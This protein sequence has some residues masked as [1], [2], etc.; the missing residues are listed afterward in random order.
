M[1]LIHSWT[2]DDYYKQQEREQEI[3]DAKATYTAKQVQEHLKQAEERAKRDSAA[4]RGQEEM[5]CG[6]MFDVLLFFS[7]LSGPRHSLEPNSPRSQPSPED[8][9]RGKVERWLQSD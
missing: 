2:K 7:R 5:S 8:V 1:D 6:D 4:G 3:A 9:S